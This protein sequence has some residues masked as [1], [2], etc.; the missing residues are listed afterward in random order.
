[1]AHAENIRKLVQT[2]IEDYQGEDCEK[3]GVLE[4]R[5]LS[6][7]LKDKSA[8]TNQFE[9]VSRL[10]GLVEKSRILNNDPLGDTLEARLK[11]IYAAPDKWIPEILSL[12]L[13]LSDRPISRT[14]VASLELPQR[15]AGQPS[16]PLE[17]DVSDDSSEDDTELWRNIDFP[18]DGS[19]D[20]EET[21]A[22]RTPTSGATSAEDG[23]DNEGLASEIDKLVIDYDPDAF[24]VAQG[25]L[26]SQEA[27]RNDNDSR[28]ALYTELELTREVIFMLLGLPSRVFDIDSDCKIKQSQDL[29]LRNTSREAVSELLQDLSFI[30]E[31][32]QEVRDW[33]RRPC[34]TAIEQTFQSVLRCN[35]NEVES[36]LN[37]TQ[38]KYLDRASAVTISLLELRQELFQ[39]SRVTRQLACI[40]TD[41]RGTLPQERPFRILEK[42][43]AQTC[44]NQSIDDVYAYQPMAKIFFECFETY[45]RSL[46]DWMETGEISGE[47]QVQLIEK[48]ND[49]IPLQNMWHDQYRVKRRASGHINAPDFLH[50]A[51]KPIFNA[52]KSVIFLKHLGPFDH[53][54]ESATSMTFDTV[55]TTIDPYN[56]SP[57]PELFHSAFMRWILPKQFAWS[58]VLIE[59]LETRVGSRKAFDAFEHI[60]LFRN[61][62]ATTSV[63]RPLFDRLER[64]KCPWNDY[65]VV[66]ELIQQHFADI[67]SIDITRLQASRPASTSSASKQSRSTASLSSL[68]LTYYLP[69]PLVNIIH[70]TTLSVYQTVFTLLTQLH[71]AQYLLQSHQV[72][73]KRT[74]TR[75]D[76]SS[77]LLRLRRETLW[78]VHTLLSHLTTLVIPTL[79]NQMRAAM[80][81]PGVK[82]IDTLV[83]IHQHYLSRIEDACFLKTRHAKLKQALIA[84]LDVCVSVADA[85]NAT[86]TVDHRP[87]ERS[88][89]HRRRRRHGRRFSPIGSTTSESDSDTQTDP[90]P[91][92]ASDIPRHTHKHHARIP[93]TAAS[94]GASTFPPEKL[95]KLSNTY[96]QLVSIFIA[97]VES[98]SKESQ[99]QHQP[100]HQPSHVFSQPDRSDPDPNPGPGTGTGVIGVREE[101]SVNFWEILAGRLVR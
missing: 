11:V 90:D 18:A 85:W 57:F 19:D 12:L 45:F 98:L 88:R 28:P 53:E 26:E 25:I 9:I 52:G 100:D 67:P 74:D 44:A 87:D 56:L 6:I 2:L 63:L 37:S 48:V 35:L 27:S 95:H 3:N 75:L 99:S 101:D 91:D 81:K 43:Y 72:I 54:V 36:T 8:R 4:P 84:L 38:A 17:D 14:R 15:D 93:S 76:A 78:L 40:C 60:Y 64:H 7:L 41:V 32:L 5:L 29:R 73:L 31:E 77:T 42:L 59:F 86:T 96:D 30:G 92:P 21:G 71:R 80:Q 50:V 58:D 49:K 22:I 13:Q 68:K 69:W 61:A 66:T 24:D 51:M 79:T 82:D 83:A 46:R 97:G 20:G 33:A 94:A 55:C 34:E 47:P 89:R 70:P 16:Q 62:S 1:M 23:S 10:D 39:C 65:H